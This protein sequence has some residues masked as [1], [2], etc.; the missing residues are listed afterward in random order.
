MT[1]RTR[2]IGMILTALVM[3]TSCTSSTGDETPAVVAAEP[4]PTP[5]AANPTAE[6]ETQDDRC[7]GGGARFVPALGKSCS[8]VYEMTRSVL[9]RYDG[10]Q[11]INAMGVELEAGVICS[12]AAGDSVKTYLPESTHIPAL[13]DALIGDFCPGDRG[14]FVPA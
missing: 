1:S 3:I 5:V 12:A 11:Q 14:N 8:D 9:V 10:Y 6:P 2:F 13:A 7:D 4:T